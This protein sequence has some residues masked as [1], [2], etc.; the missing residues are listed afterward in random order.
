[1]KIS[2]NPETDVLNI[3]FQESPVEKRERE[4]PDRILDYDKN[5]NLVRLE[6]LN[7]SQG[8]TNPQRVEYSVILPNPVT[9]EAKLLSLS[10]RCAFMQLPLEERRR[11]LAAQTEVMVE[12]YEQDTE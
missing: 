12:H 7:A 3:Y 1:M 8:V 5:G 4:K 10:D 2:Y 11:I 6:I 9:E